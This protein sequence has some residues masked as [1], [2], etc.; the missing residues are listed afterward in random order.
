MVTFQVEGQE[1]EGQEDAVPFQWNFKKSP[2]GLCYLAN[3]QANG[4]PI[5]NGLH[6]YDPEHKCWHF[7]GYDVP[8]KADQPYCDKAWLNIDVAKDKILQSKCA[9]I[10][11]GKQYM[12]D[13]TVS[14]TRT[15]WT[16]AKVT[17]D[18]IE[19]HLTEGTRNGE[20]V[21]D[22]KFILTVKAD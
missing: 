5:G 6:A 9:F 17:D 7:I 16:F 8:Q 15:R 2:T 12:P 21:P 1:D 13:G 11:E 19:I 22:A 4:T 14:E 18:S 3:A 10:T 20:S